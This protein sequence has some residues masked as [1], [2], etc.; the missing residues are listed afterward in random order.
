MKVLCV[1]GHV[2]EIGDLTGR[3]EKAGYMSI[4]PSQG[5]TLNAYVWTGG[6]EDDMGHLDQVDVC[7]TCGQPV[8]PS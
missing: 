1:K 8:R 3:I 2:N 6:T 4:C 5:C 7:E